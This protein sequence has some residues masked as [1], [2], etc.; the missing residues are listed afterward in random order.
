VYILRYVSPSI[1]GIKV[2]VISLGT[3]YLPRSSEKDEYGVYKVDVDETKKLIRY[4]YDSGI[5]F[6]DTANRYHGAVSPVPLTH[7]G[8]AEKLIGKIISELNLERESLVIAT[9]VAG[10]MASWPNGSGL[11]RK[12]ILWQIKESLKRLQ[13]EYIDVYYAHRFDPEV[14]KRET[15]ST[16]NDLVRL[17]YVRYLGMSNVPAHE[18]IEYQMITDRYG[19]EPISFLQ[20]RYNWLDRDIEKDIIPIAKRFGMALAVYSPLA[21]GLLTGKYI[22]ISKKQWVIP[23]MSRGEISESVR[24]MFTNENLNKLIPFIEFAKSKGATATQLAIAWIL[25][26]SEQIGVPIIPIVSVSNVNQLEEILCSLDIKLSSDDMKYLDE[27][28]KVSGVSQ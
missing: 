12:H 19:Y 5:N 23:P 18:L 6:I 11:S 25:H 8:Y 1:C 2:S 15:M 4:T 20:Y 13:M 24:K 9:K 14:P 21:Q 3:W 17:G 22:D 26:R 16:F 10:E 7:I 27:I 28:L